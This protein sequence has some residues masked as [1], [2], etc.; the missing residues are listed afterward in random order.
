MKA[1]WLTRT[2]VH[3][4][5]LL[6]TLVAKE[7]KVRYRSTVLGYAWSLLQPFVFGAVFY[8]VIKVMLRVPQEDYLVFLLCGLFP[9]HCFQNSVGGSV[10]VFLTNSPL[11]RKVRFSH[12]VLVYAVV[13]N[14][15][16]HLA[17][18]LPV[19]LVVKFAVDGGL[20]LGASILGF[21]L[22][23]PALGLTAAG[24]ALM[25]AS[26]N[27]FFRDIERMVGLLL[28]VLF[29]GTPILYPP[30]AVPVEWRW[31]LHI[32]PVAGA[33]SC[34]RSCVMSGV[35]SWA[36]YATAI[37]GGGVLFLM[38]KLVFRRADHW[39]AERV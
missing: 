4:W 15:G 7:I 26:V 29:Y 33:I 36:D 18:T 5:D 23:L 11:L 30:S 13:A 38:A 22:L 20:H 25:A 2:Q 17:L 35:F 14:E 3:R 24:I 9:W 19:M 37:I 27:V 6:V 34:W 21:M 32:H 8:L 16:C 10:T 39:I 31:V 28:M 1:K 12:A